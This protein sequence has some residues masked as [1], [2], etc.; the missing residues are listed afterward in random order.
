MLLTWKQR[1]LNLEKELEKK[2][3]DKVITNADL[4]SN[5]IP[6][7]FQEYSE[8]IKKLKA[9]ALNNK[10]LSLSGDKIEE[11]LN[12]LNQA[13]G[14]F[15]N[16]IDIKENRFT[17]FKV[18][19]F[20]KLGNK[21]YQ[22]IPIIFNKAMK[23]NDLSTKMKDYLY[24]NKPIS[25][26]FNCLY[27]NKKEIEPIQKYEESLFY[28]LDYIRKGEKENDFDSKCILLLGIYFDNIEKDSIIFLKKDNNINKIAIKNDIKI[29]SKNYNEKNSFENLYNT[30]IFNINKNIPKFKK[31][32]LY[33]KLISL[34][35]YKFIEIFFEKEKNYELTKKAIKLYFESKNE[36][37]LTMEIK[38]YA[39]LY[40]INF[41]EEKYFESLQIIEKLMEL[42]NKNKD[43]NL[44]SK[45]INL[46]INFD[47]LRFKS[48]EKY[49]E[50]KLNFIEFFNLDKYLDKLCE[51]KERIKNDIPNIEEIE[52][53]IYS[54]QKEYAKKKIMHFKD[55]EKYKSLF[56]LFNHY[57]K[58]YS[59]DKNM[60]R[61]IKQIK[62]DCLNKISDN[63]IKENKKEDFMEKIKEISEL[64]YEI[65]SEY[66][67][68]NS[69][70]EIIDIMLKVINEKAEYFNRNNLF[71][72]SENISD[73]G[74][75]EEPDNIDLLTEKS[76]SNSERGN[77]IKAININ[78]KILEKEPNNL[79]A[80]LNKIIN[81]SKL[82]LNDQKNYIKDLINIIDKTN[83]IDNNSKIIVGKAIDVLID[84]IKKCDNKIYYL[85]KDEKGN[86]I[87]PKAKLI[88]FSYY[89]EEIQ[90]KSSE[91][92]KIYF[93][94]FEGK[95]LISEFYDKETKC[96]FEVF[97]KD[98][99]I[100]ENIEKIIINDNI[101]VEVKVNI[102]F[103]YTRMDPYF[104]NILKCHKVPLNFIEFLFKFKYDYS[105][106]IYIGLLVL[107]TLIKNINFYLSESLKKYLFNYIE[108]N[109]KYN[110]FTINE[111]DIEEYF[112][113]NKYDESKLE[114]NFESIKENFKK[115]YYEELINKVYMQDEINMQ[116]LQYLK[117]NGIDLELIIN[118]NKIKIKNNI[119]MILNIFIEYIKDEVN[120]I[121]TSDLESINSLLEI[122][123]DLYI[124]DNLIKLIY[125]IFRDKEYKHVIPIKL[126]INLSKE[127]I[128]LSDPSF[129][130]GNSTFF[131]NK[132]KDL[133]TD[134]TKIDI[135]IDILYNY[136][137]LKTKT[138]NIKDKINDSIFNN[139]CFYII[140]QKVSENNKN[141]IIE[142]FKINEKEM[143]YDIKNIF[144]MMYKSKQLEE[145][146][147][148]EKKNLLIKEL[149]DKIKEG[150]EL[151]INTTTSLNKVIKENKDNNIIM[152]QSI[153][154]ININV[155]NNKKIDNQLSEQLINIFLDENI[156]LDKEV[157]DNLVICLMNIM[158]NCE[159]DEQLSNK[160]YNNLT[161]FSEKKILNKLEFLVISL[162]IL[163][164]KH[165]SFNKQ[166]ILNCLYLLANENIT[167]SNNLFD[168]LEHI[169]LNSFQ[170]QNLEKEI[171]NALFNL[172]NKNL[173]LIES[174]S[175]C[176][177]N[178]LKNKKKNE[179]DNLVKYNMK[180]FEEL[181]INNSIN[182]NLI[183]ILFKASDDIFSENEIVRNFVFFT[184][185][186][187][188]LKQ[189]NI[190]DL[191]NYIDTKNVK[192][193]DYHLKLIEDNLNIKGN[194][195]L[196][197]EIIERNEIGLISKIDADKIITN[198]YYDFYSGINLLNNIIQTKII[199][200]D[201]SLI[202][203]SNY[204]YNNHKEDEHDNLHLKIKDLFSLISKNQKIPKEVI[205]KLY[206]DNFSFKEE[207]QIDDKIILLGDILSKNKIPKRYN[208]KIY[209]IMNNI[210]IK[211]D[212]K[213]KFLEIIFL[214]SLEIGEII[215]IELYEKYF[216]LISS[217]EELDK[218]KYILINK[219][220]IENIKELYYKKFHEFLK[221]TDK[222]NDE[223]IN[224]L[225]KII[226]IIDFNDILYEDLK[227]Q[228]INL[229]II[230]DI[231]ENL[232]IQFIYWIVKNTLDIEY[233]KLLI[234]ILKKDNIKKYFNDLEENN[235]N[236]EKI[237]KI[238]L[239]KIVLDKEITKLSE[240]CEENL[241]Q[242]KSTII[243][244][245]PIDLEQDSQGIIIKYIQFLNNIILTNNLNKKR[246]FD[247][248]EFFS[249]IK[250]L[251][252]INIINDKKYLEYLKE[253][254]ILSNIKKTKNY[255]DNISSLLTKKLIKND[256]E[257]NI[258]KTFI[259][260]IDIDSEKNLNNFFNFYE[261]QKINEILFKSI[262]FNDLS[263]TITLN[264]L[265]QKIIF[266]LIDAYEGTNSV[267][268]NFAKIIYE[269]NK[270]EIEDIYIFLN[271]GK[272]QFIKL[273][274][275]QIEILEY[276]FKETKFALNKKNNK[277]ETLFDI[278]TN[279]EENLWEYKIKQLGL[280][281]KL[282][283]ER[284][285]DEIFSELLKN[286]ISINN[287]L[288]KTIEELSQ[289]YYDIE[290]F[291][292]EG[293]IENKPIEKMNK[294]DI[295]N[296]VK[297]EKTKKNIN[298]DSFIPELFSIIRQAN[299]LSDGY[300][301]R[302]VQIIAV[303]LFLFSPKNKGLFTQIKTGEGKTTIVAILA[304]INALKGKYVDILTSSE[305]LAE[306]DSKEKE[307][308][309]SMFNLTVT[310]AKNDHFH[311]YN[312]VYGD[313]LSFEGDLL[314]TLFREAPYKFKFKR[315][316]Q[317]I[318]I[319]EVDNMC[320]D[321]LSA[322]TQLV[323]GF[324]GYGALNVLYPIIYQNLNM[325]DQFIL[326]GRYPDINKDNIREKTIEKL[327]E[328]TENIFEEGLKNKVFVFPKHIEEFAR[329]QIKKWCES[330]Y[331]AKNVYQ[332][333][334]HYVISGKEGNMVIA[335]VDYENTGVIHLRMHWGNGLHQFL[336]LK[337]GV[338]LENEAINTTFLY[339]YNFIKKY[340]TPRENN[341]Y[342]LTGTLG[343]NSTRGLFKKLF[344]VN[345]IIVPTFK[346]SNYINLYPKL[347]PTE[348][349]WKNAIVENILNPINKKR[350][351]LVICKTIIKVNLLIEELKS[352]NYPEN[353]IERYDRNDTNFKFKE[354]YDPGYVILATNLAGRGTDI[355]LTDEVEKNGGMHVILTFLP[356]NQRVEEQALGRTARSGKNGSG[357]IIMEIQIRNESLKKK[358]KNNTI[359]QIISIIR[360][361]I[362]KEKMNEIEKNKINSLKLKSEIFDKF[363][364]LFIEL[365]KYLKSYN[366]SEE[367][368]QGIAD[369]VEEKWGLWMN[370]NGLDEEIDY[371]KKVE[372]EKSYEE[373]QKGIKKEYFKSSFINLLNP[374]NYF[375][376]SDYSSAKYTDNDSCFFATYLNKMKNMDEIKTDSDKQNLAD[377]IKE[378]NTKLQENIQTS[379]EGMYSTI[380]N[381][382]TNLEENEIK[383]CDDCKNDIKKKLEIIGKI[384]Q[385]LVENIQIIEKS[386]GNERHVIK[387][388]NE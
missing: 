195:Y 183:E 289:I 3:Y 96:L 313:S 283:N 268:K 351:T 10:A 304:T 191:F 330:A 316:H 267:T 90:Y 151:N 174:I 134:E 367:K 126:L 157:F 38:A 173:S 232:L 296:W 336:Q 355:K 18:L 187:K 176:L 325:I 234:N 269:I 276:S 146:I 348:E 275:L 264:D 273:N 60:I 241:E 128:E 224:F 312:I 44:N 91:L 217:F 376:F 188:E 185:K 274:N 384:S 230:S 260:I 309:Y 108:K 51:L 337:H 359:F 272:N 225:T 280:P 245:S 362:E 35:S 235:D 358:M 43:L 11:C 12:L 136:L 70:K 177:L 19:F 237:I 252:E 379:L 297:S 197:N 31:N 119:E 83:I 159:L 113:K 172:L 249:V 339:H 1:Y 36:E 180:K 58:I 112:E 15:P 203:L 158:K 133:L 66:G 110:N 334:I 27:R 24:I 33:Q 72:I 295:L 228:I 347:L 278:F 129:N 37:N 329:N 343:S 377:A 251:R 346:K 181:I 132:E 236:F 85:F 345:I 281:T 131:I 41:E 116:L 255:T 211:L 105:D 353:K 106:F 8:Q 23:Y 109:I 102:L 196:L 291:Y 270:W 140:K 30:I 321:N 124:K 311:K 388:K 170:E 285:L 229:L 386:M 147:P 373:F 279:Y 301:P 292:K 166:S 300:Y 57:I 141:K 360:E 42:V 142:I 220:A 160:F 248:I 286:N 366:Y 117:E 59:N 335:P 152:N 127:I 75:Q 206:L 213:M 238:N 243:Q 78:N 118:N 214:Y 73:L 381:L 186:L 194:I 84:I 5:N 205:N 263:K 332:P 193:V 190:N 262:L 189:E 207:E 317:C 97:Y 331:N 246:I 103:L 326:E 125:E 40:K 368:I 94:T 14:I 357:I 39:I 363:T 165:Y 148:N 356:D 92:L 153:S 361:Y 137:T 74:L 378:T 218:L 123:C 215:P 144:D 65:S 130:N 341:I 352:R 294:K 287:D 29:I 95:D 71:N 175:F 340:I 50:N 179:I 383:P 143:P 121:T 163:T 254:W 302:K 323:T 299:Y 227:K 342:G 17:K 387:K 55:N 80:K 21:N 222:I 372:I 61:E 349:E 244:Y 16:D 168:D 68:N 223:Q 167:K 82:Y 2:N 86:N 315:G 26:Y 28:F 79:S 107:V 200:S 169:I 271:F 266:N 154:L 306:R 293:Q 54:L 45:L 374:F 111:R 320:L 182:L 135:L 100:L 256:F 314:R 48:L 122:N 250:D 310:H 114:F 382:N 62:L 22:E 9:I 369:D 239:Y 101:L 145:N 156:K 233:R 56:I 77:I 164:Q 104:I 4:L 99:V 308:F 327:K 202:L 350:V 87:F 53:K 201:N 198:L 69:N 6:W 385:G 370:K 192:I 284:T 13:V 261:K 298:E 277:N 265:K 303:L 318:I 150:F 208:E 258:I 7:F 115:K 365:K 333:N 32:Q 64:K 209:N 288:L 210:N 184:K 47:L 253:E 328:V 322:A 319:D 216:S 380:S 138:Y 259:K 139:L 247:Y 290:S 219:N 171:F 81:I 89:I 307:K 63:L 282:E 231:E 221:N 204:L 25:N 371:M 46:G 98:R 338:K 20:Q 88:N 226:I 199:L 257:N 34:I 120:K 161:N 93:N 324:G 305:I 212:I 375:S 149:E 52:S 364:N 49:I 178:S 354:R 67:E 240:K 162:K 242:V 344:G 155:I 76:K